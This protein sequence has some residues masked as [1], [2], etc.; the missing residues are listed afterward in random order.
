MTSGTPLLNTDEPVAGPEQSPP[1][2]SWVWLVY[3]IAA[4]A[5][6]A[7]IAWATLGEIARNP[8]RAATADLGSFG[9]V[10]I[11]LTTNPSTPKAV[12]T[13]QLSFMPMDPRRRTV[14]LDN[15]SFQYGR[16]GSDQPVGS[17]EAQLMPDGS[18][19]FMG[20]AQFPAVGNW[21]VR[22][23]FTKGG[24]QAEVRFTVYVN[25]AQ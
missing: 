16:E 24:A 2:R 4:L 6:I 14:P 21:W 9:L 15:I 20:G 13:V 5:L 1:G 19:M 7:A 23:S 8:A 25:P 17:G 12:G 3:L 10:T 11:H 22:V 18:G